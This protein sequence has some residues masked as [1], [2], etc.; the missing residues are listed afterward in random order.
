LAKQHEEI[1]QPGRDEPLRLPADNPGLQLLTKLRDEAHR[2]AV[3]Y[4]RNLRSRR[5]H[6]S[7]LD[8]VE[9]LG[10]ARRRTLLRAFGSVEALLQVSETDL[11]A[12]EGIGPVL[13]QR[14]QKELRK[15]R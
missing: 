1:Y 5:M 9:G 7:A 11:A 15:N 4:H 2:F 13:A 8:K 12:M 3:T 6:I 14:I 10:P